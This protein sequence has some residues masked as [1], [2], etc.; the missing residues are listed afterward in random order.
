[1]LYYWLPWKHM[2]KIR[3]L[4]PRWCFCKLL[5]YSKKHTQNHHKF[6][7]NLNEGQ[8]ILTRFRNLKPHLR[9]AAR[10]WAQRHV[11]KSHPEVRRSTSLP[12][13][14]SDQV[15]ELISTITRSKSVRTAFEFK[16]KMSIDW[17]A[18][19]H[20]QKQALN[21]FDKKPCQSEKPETPRN[22]TGFSCGDTWRGKHKLCAYLCI[23]H[24]HL[25]HA[26]NI[27]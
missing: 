12:S 5:E 7:A 19:V 4:L 8:N 21:P 18:E 2:R 13:A 24:N 23:Y 20:V 25:C 10:C 26:G 14:A 3:L 17:C 1:M 6:T 11:E 15:P 9:K 22:V 27:S 16:D